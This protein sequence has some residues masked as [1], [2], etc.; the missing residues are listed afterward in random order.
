MACGA[1][2]TKYEVR[3]LCPVAAPAGRRY[4]RL[5]TVAKPLP[6]DLHARLGWWLEPQ[7]TGHCYNPPYACSS[8]ANKPSNVRCGEMKPSLT[9]DTLFW[10]AQCARNQ[11]HCTVCPVKLN[12]GAHAHDAGKRDICFQRAITAQSV[13]TLRHR[14]AGSFLEVGELSSFRPPTRRSSTTPHH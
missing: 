12:G 10:A 1:Q 3:M 6:A 5:W 14:F 13:C 2:S 4:W 9:R 11:R 7:P 8:R